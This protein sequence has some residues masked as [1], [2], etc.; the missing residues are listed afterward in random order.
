MSNDD[1]DKRILR[2]VDEVL[3]SFGPKVR[4]ALVYYMRRSLSLRR[5]QIPRMPE[6]FSLALEKIFGVVGRDVEKEIVRRIEKEFGM[7]AGNQIRFAEAVEKAAAKHRGT[8]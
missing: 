3:E 4:R 5:Y 7:T 8:G 1:F 2:C 6:T